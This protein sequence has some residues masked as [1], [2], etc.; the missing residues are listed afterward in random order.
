MVDFFNNFFLF[1]EN[2]DLYMLLGCFEEDFIKFYI[3]IHQIWIV[4][5][6]KIFSHGI[7]YYRSNHVFSQMFLGDDLAH[8]IFEKLHHWWNN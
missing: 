4:R 2:L 1:F 7:Y 5:K 8:F 6:P 3:S